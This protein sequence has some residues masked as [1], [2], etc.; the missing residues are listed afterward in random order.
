MVWTCGS[1]DAQIRYGFGT[2]HHVRVHE[3]EP[4]GI[5][6]A[7]VLKALLEGPQFSRPPR[8]QGLALNHNQRVGLACFFCRPACHIRC[9]VRTLIIHEEEG[10]SHALIQ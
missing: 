1:N 2:V 7:C 10:H 3:Q 5:E 9:A 8:R 4:C 6:R